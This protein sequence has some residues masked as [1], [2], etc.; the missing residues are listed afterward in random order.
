[1][2]VKIEDKIY[3][4]NKEPIMLILSQRDKKLIG[5]MFLKN[6]KYCSFPIRMSGSEIEEFMKL[7]GEN[8]K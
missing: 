5:S 4:S 7:K 3:N 6:H 2:E 8:K 1:M